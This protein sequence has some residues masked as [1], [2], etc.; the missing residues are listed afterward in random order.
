MLIINHIILALLWGLFGVLH[1]VLAAPGWK[2]LMQRWLGRGYKYYHFAYSLFAAV[3]LIGILVFQYT[4]PGYLLFVAPVWIK[5]LLCLPVLAGLTIMLVV[6][7]KY[8][9]SLS[10]ISVFYKQ[11]PP[12]VLEQSGLH[13]YVRHPLYFG[14]LLFIWSLFFVFPYLN[15]LVACIV[16]TAY[17]VLG[18]KLEEKK[19]VAQFGEK[20]KAY[21]QGVPMLIPGF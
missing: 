20:Y 5:V 10:G 18:A 11:Q 1:S 12:V 4:M 14:T 9:F 2:R 6:I 19:L 15:N 13:R 16:I 7:R 8:F 21:Q 3:T 17:T